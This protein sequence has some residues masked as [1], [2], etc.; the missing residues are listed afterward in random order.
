[1]R[2]RT[3]AGMRSGRLW[4]EAGRQVSSTS[5][6][7]A[8]RVSATSSTASAPQ[9]ITSGDLGAPAGDTACQR[10]PAG[11]LG[12]A[13][14]TAF[15]DERLGGLDGDRRIATV[16]IAPDRLAELLVQRRPAD[17]DDVVVP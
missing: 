9:P 15:L 8:R 2:A 17:E 12:D 11:S 7:P 3:A 10:R 5:G 16:G 6:M 4:S 1:M 14:G 13:A